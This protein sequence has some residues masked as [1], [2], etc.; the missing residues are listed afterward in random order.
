MPEMQIDVEG[1]NRIRFTVEE[2]TADKIVT[3]AEYDD[4]TILKTTMVGDNVSVECNKDLEVQ[5]DGYTVKI[6]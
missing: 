5:P 1:R 2:Q 4:G 3:V 6:V